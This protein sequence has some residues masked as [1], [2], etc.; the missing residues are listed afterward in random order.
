MLYST[1]RG[2]PEG[3]SGVKGRLMLSPGV[4]DGISIF[5]GDVSQT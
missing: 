2:G 3:L 5:Q 1:W 4:R